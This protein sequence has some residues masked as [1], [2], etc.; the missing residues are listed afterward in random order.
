MIHIRHEQAEEKNTK[1]DM[2]RSAS[3][4]KLPDSTHS[5]NHPV[6]VAVVTPSI[7]DHVY[8]PS[9]R[10]IE[11]PP[12]REVSVPG[13]GLKKDHNFCAWQYRRPNEGHRWDRQSGVLVEFRAAVRFEMVMQWHRGSR[14][15][16]D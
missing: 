6:I 8:S 14:R 16:R 5:A 10:T 4:P 9:A 15:Q 1:Q 3:Q 11:M 7:P 2:P 13:W 12:T